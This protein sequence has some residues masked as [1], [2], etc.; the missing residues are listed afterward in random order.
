MQL[1]NAEF[2]ALVDA[3]QGRAQTV[4][5]GLLR[6]PEDAR[7]VVQE[8]FLRVHLH[9][10]SFEE[11]ASFSTWLYR[12]VVNLSIDSLRKRPPGHWAAIE[13]QF[14]E[15]ANAPRYGV[16]LESRELDPHE[17]LHGKE[18]LSA[19]RVALD[20]LPEHHREAIVLREVQELSYEEMAQAIGK[21]IGTVMSRLFYA[22]K[23][24]QAALQEVR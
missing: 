24:I 19:M 6:N 11:Q 17:A 14:D 9:M 20:G 4:A 1:T 7:E 8:A 10:E 3:H 13:S 22:R 23:S 12:I 21:S 2:R 18:V 16:D 15:E 5:Y